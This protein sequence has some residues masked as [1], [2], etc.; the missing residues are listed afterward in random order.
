MKSNKLAQIALLLWVVTV[1]VIAWFF[2]RGNTTAGTDGRTAVVMQHGERDFVMTEMRGLLAATQGILE[3]ANQGDMQ[4]IIKSARSAG[5]A[6]AADVRPTLM[7]KLPIEFKQLG[8]SLHRDM[9]DIAKAAEEGVPVQELLKMTSSALAK[10][11][12][13][14]SAWQI[15]AGD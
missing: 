4:R 12:A 13:C 2:I 10:C 6:G 9:D 1:A 11:V 7:A 3:G 8:L 14:H 15:K 5:M